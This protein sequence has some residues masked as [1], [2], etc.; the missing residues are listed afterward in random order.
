MTHGGDLQSLHRHI[1]KSIL[2]AEYGGLQ[3]SFDNTKW[4][5]QIINDE[6][7]FN[8]LEMYTNSH[9]NANHWIR[10][11]SVTLDWIEWANWHEY[12]FG[13]LLKKPSRFWRT[14]FYLPREVFNAGGVTHHWTQVI[15][16]NFR[17]YN[18]IRALIISLLFLLLFV[19]AHGRSENANV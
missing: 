4:R 2:P 7:Y 15:S 10:G 16:A 5:E 3:G 17:K 8:R 13:I 12:Y 14:F 11:L 1:P 19:W 6:E 9:E 18:I